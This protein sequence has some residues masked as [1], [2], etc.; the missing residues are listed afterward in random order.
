VSIFITI[1]IKE[2]LSTHIS[3]ISTIML[4]AT[5]YLVNQNLLK[6]CSQ[7]A[8]SGKLVL[9]NPTGKFFYDAWAIKDEYKNTAVENVLN[10]LPF[11]IGEAR[12]VSL[13]SGNCYFAHSDIDDRYHLNLTGTYST[14]VDLED[15]QTFWLQ[16]DGVWYEMDAGKIHTAVNAGEHARI[17]LLVR[18]LLPLTVLKD[19]V[20]MFIRLS[21]KNARYRFDNTLSPWLNRAVKRGIVSNFEINLASVYFDIEKENI[22]ECVAIT[23][24][25]F[26]YEY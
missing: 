22:T 4:T 1:L 23:P 10:A 19:P 26:R 13:E 2:K 5:P 17:Q 15:R 24:G 25:Q 6:T 14:L 7:Y 12:L 16:P 18:K 9:N 21:G 20:N 3:L 8:Q 11:P